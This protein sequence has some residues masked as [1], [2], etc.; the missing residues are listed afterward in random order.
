MNSEP[1][2]AEVIAS[3]NAS[4]LLSCFNDS[5]SLGPRSLLTSHVDVYLNAGGQELK[6]ILIAELQSVRVFSNTVTLN[7][8]AEQNM[9]R[10]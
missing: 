9:F 6:S 7:L 8:R 10:V 5:C 4:F 2:S 1:L 3:K